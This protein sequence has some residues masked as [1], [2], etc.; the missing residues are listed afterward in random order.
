MHLHKC[1]AALPPAPCRPLPP[2]GRLAQVRAGKRSNVTRV[3]VRESELISSL[4]TTSVAPL[5]G[6]RGRGEEDEEDEALLL[7]D[8]LVV[9][10]SGHVPTRPIHLWMQVSVSAPPPPPL[11]TRFASTHPH[12]RPPASPPAQPSLFSRTAAAP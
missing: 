1:N 12:T 3:R 10:E 9:V 11:C 6:L 8:G 5:A 4:S 7:Q 2:L